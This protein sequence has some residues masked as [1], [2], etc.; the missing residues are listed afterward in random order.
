MHISLLAGER[1]RGIKL[2]PRRRK[3]GN[4][5]CRACESAKAHNAGL[6]AVWNC[7]A[8]GRGTTTPS[9]EAICVF[10]LDVDGGA[11]GPE[12]EPDQVPIPDTFILAARLEHLGLDSR[13][14]RLPRFQ[15]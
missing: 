4:S 5:V 7:L 8:T 2:K 10:F 1:L 11:A 15:P 13:H 14:A 3:R 9:P 6:D 12:Q